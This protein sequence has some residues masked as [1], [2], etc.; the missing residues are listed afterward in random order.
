MTMNASPATAV[1]SPKKKQ[2]NQ[3]FLPKPPPTAP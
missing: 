2:I 1:T 3:F